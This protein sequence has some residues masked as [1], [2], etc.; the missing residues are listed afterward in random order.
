MACM[1]LTAETQDE[2]ISAL[3][4]NAPNPGK[5]GLTK[6]VTRKIIDAKLGF[7]GLFAILKFEDK[8]RLG[9]FNIAQG[10]FQ[11]ILKLKST[12]FK[13]TCGRTL[14]LVFYPDMKVIELWD[15]QTMKKIKVKKI[16]IKNKFFTNFTMASDL[17]SKV[18][19]SGMSGDSFDKRFFGILNLETFKFNQFKNHALFGNAFD[20]QDVY[21]RCNK[22]MTKV[23]FF[24]TINVYVSLSTNPPTSKRNDS[25]GYMNYANS[26]NLTLTIGGAILDSDGNLMKKYSKSM[27]FPVLGDDFYIQYKQNSKE[28]EPNL[29]VRDLNSHKEVAI[30]TTDVGI[31]TTY[32]QNT[33]FTTDQQL[34]AS[35]ISDRILII[36]KKNLK[37]KIYPLGISRKGISF[38]NVPKGFVGEKWICKLSYPKGTK[39]VI[40]DGPEGMTFN[41][42]SNT[43]IWNKPTTKG[44][45]D[46]LLS[47]TK[48]NE[49]EFYKEIKIIVKKK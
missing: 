41:A 29:I 35:S 5:N 7:F 21:I 11:K 9:V 25:F 38:G 46:V 19:V 17:N 24:S 31:K 44:T 28:G 20:K 18:F 49:E 6:K 22:N 34:L 2:Y 13:Y 8:P 30:L 23:A 16:S 47:V 45:Q 12:N 36:D 48:P 40:E 39:V 32:S 10:K 42:D 14:L 37:L 4:K 33:D 27:L 15:L 26:Y 43:L 3:L 1:L